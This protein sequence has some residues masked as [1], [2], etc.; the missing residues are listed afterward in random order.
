METEKIT[1]E[2]PKAILNFLMTIGADLPD[3]FNE[4]IKT[5]FQADYDLFQQDTSVFL[6][7]EA[8]AHKAGLDEIL[9]PKTV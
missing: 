6:D 5:Q 8:L 1:V 2:V 3:Y 7:V 9:R 4:S